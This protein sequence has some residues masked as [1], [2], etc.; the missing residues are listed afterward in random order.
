MR[1]LLVTILTA[2]IC[3]VAWAQ[4]SNNNQLVIIKIQEFKKGYT[5]NT[6]SIIHITEADGSYRTI[7]L[8]K[9]GKHLAED[10]PNQKVIHS[11]LLKYLNA[12]YEIVSHNLGTCDGIV[13]SEDYVLIKE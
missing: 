7:D 4:D 9:V 12:S 5:G 10:N 6:A 8:E 13:Y 11:E 2:M 1:K 3:S